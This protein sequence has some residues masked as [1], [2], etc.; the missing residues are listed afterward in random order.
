M[1]RGRSLT[2]AFALLAAVAVGGCTAAAGNAYDSAKDEITA[3]APKD[4]KTQAT[5][6][7]KQMN[8]DR[9]T[10]LPLVGDPPQQGAPLAQGA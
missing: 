3:L 5:P 6:A 4:V 2:F 8:I 7:M 9:I 1:S 10:I